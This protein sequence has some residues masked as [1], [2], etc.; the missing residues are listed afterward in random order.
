MKSVLK[1]R[2]HRKGIRP[3]RK[4]TLKVRL[5]TLPTRDEHIK[6]IDQLSD[7]ISLAMRDPKFKVFYPMTYGEL[8]AHKG[9]DAMMGAILHQIKLMQ[10]GYDYFRNHRQIQ[11]ADLAG[12]AVVEFD[13]V[14]SKVH[15]ACDTCDTKAVL[16]HCPFSAWNGITD[17]AELC[18]K[19]R[20]SQPQVK[21]TAEMASQALTH[22][23]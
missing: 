4:G 17:M 3:F 19:L 23:S 22:L 14:Y 9:H 10:R 12:P 13:P 16:G 1:R 2:K 20:D 5:V 18:S 11:F 21:T 8:W 7:L 6:R 15:T